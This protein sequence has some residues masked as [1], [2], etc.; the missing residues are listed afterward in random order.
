MKN[1]FFS[2]LMLGLSLNVACGGGST[3]GQNSQTSSSG[4]SSTQNPTTTAPTTTSAPTTSAP[5]TTTPTTATATVTTLSAE[6]GNNTSASSSFA[7]WSNGDIAPTNVSKVDVHKLLYAGTAT[8]VYAHLMP[9]FGNS[10]HKNVGYTSWDA[11]QV[12]LQV[13]DM[14]SRGING[15]V[16]DWYGPGNVGGNTATQL[17]FAEAAKHPGF[18]V[19]VM[20]DAGG[21]SGDPTTSVVSLLNYIRTNYETSSSYTRKG[22]RPVVPF[23]GVESLAVNWTTVQTSVAGN[24]IYVFENASG[25]SQATS[26]GAFSWVGAFDNPND[27]GQSYLDSFYSASLSHM[28]EHTFASTKKGFNDT[29]ASWSANRI[30]N[31]NCGSTWVNTFKEI[32]NFYSQTNQLESLQLVT[33]NDYEEGTE[34]ETGI[35]NCMSVSQ[36]ELQGSTLSWSVVSS[37]SLTSLDTIDHF[38]VY[39]STDGTNLTLVADNL[40]NTATSA[41]LSQFNVPSGAKYYVKAVGINSVINHMSPMSD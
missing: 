38:A 24:P 33:W 2:I 13:N 22:G 16:I 32:S 15:L 4:A 37:S 31:Q 18:E 9:W 12:A 10:S 28:T 14:I 17:I 25:F 21:V 7:G 5:T 39:A 36:P 29:M 30:I 20:V 34:I 23:F 1:F 8:K 27:W 11:S 26:D 6:T 40:A 41:D 19:A 3:S 35:D